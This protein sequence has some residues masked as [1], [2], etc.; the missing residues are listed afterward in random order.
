[1]FGGTLLYLRSLGALS[2]IA[3]LAIVPV[4][5]A[6][7]AETAGKEDYA[8]YNAVLDEIQFPQGSTH[9]L[10]AGDTL[11][12]KCGADSG[13]PIL[14]NGCSGMIVPPDTPEKIRQL[15]NEGFDKMGALTWSD[16]E[17]KNMRSI[18]LQD[19]FVTSW[20]H[21]LVGPDIRADNSKEWGSPNC[22][23]YFSSVGFNP[24]KTEAVVFVLLSSNMENV[25]SSGD[26]FLY[27]LDSAKKWNPNGRV[28]YFA[29]GSDQN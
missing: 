1:M 25:P 28:Q 16:F 21:L 15:L 24:G 5:T 6:K 9:A 20:Q 26:Y 10:I 14:F 22:T 23:F 13:N 19:S 17:H 3:S 27:R 2:F 29:S 11:N 4:Q 8:V 7:E 12:F 18:K